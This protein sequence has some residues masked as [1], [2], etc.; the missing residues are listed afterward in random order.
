MMT[1]S[2]TRT[3]FNHFSGWPDILNADHNLKEVSIYTYIFFGRS[4]ADDNMDCL[5]RAM[6]YVVHSIERREP[7]IS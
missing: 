1:H 7:K 2:L 3:M 6:F 4:L 5:G